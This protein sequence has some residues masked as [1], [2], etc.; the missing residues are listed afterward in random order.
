[1]SKLGVPGTLQW[2]NV[3]FETFRFALSPSHTYEDLHQQLTSV[4]LRGRT[5]QLQSSEQASE[6]EAGRSR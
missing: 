6:L 1:M 5:K 4:P 3:Q 2:E